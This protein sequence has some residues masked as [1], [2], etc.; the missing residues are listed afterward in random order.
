MGR[1]LYLLK[2]SRP[3]LS[4]PIRE[5]ARMMSSPTEDHM[6]EMYRVIKWVLDNPDIGLKMKP[7]VNFDEDGNIIWEM[8]GICDSTWGSNKDDGRSI[9]GYILYFM[10]VPIAWKS[11][12]QVLCT[13]SSAE[14]EYVSLSELTKEI[15]FAIQLLKDFGFKVKTPIKIYIDNIGAIH[16]ARNNIGGA[17]TRHVNVRYHFVRELHEQGMIELIFV[18]SEDNEA[19]TMTKNATQAEFERH[20]P[21]LVGVVPETLRSK[22]KN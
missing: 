13:L 11:K 10:G 7:V 19:D 17:G 8:V 4:N 20:T 15:L 18:R 14:A 6:E 2:H 21:K 12:S 22:N 16:M 9:T 3:E 1:L 5:L